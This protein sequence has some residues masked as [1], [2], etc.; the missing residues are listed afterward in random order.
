M[1]G[2]ELKIHFHFRRR[3]F[4]ILVIQG[5]C[6]YTIVMITEIILYSLIIL[7]DNYNLTAFA[8]IHSRYTMQII[9]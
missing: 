5:E 3:L 4:E 8:G 1:I 9:K 7:F 2:S 6:T